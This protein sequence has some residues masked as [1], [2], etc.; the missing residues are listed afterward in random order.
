[1][2][3]EAQDFLLQQLNDE[4]NYFKLKTAFS[5]FT[6][7]VRDELVT[8]LDRYKQLGIITYKIEQNSKGFDVFIKPTPT[9]SKININF[10]II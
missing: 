6:S 10:Q 5:T 8:L 4:L 1:M 3:K 7:S 9:I 2:N